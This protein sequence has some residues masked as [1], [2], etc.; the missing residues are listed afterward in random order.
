M[1]NEIITKTAA[2]DKI[3]FGG[4]FGMFTKN[5]ENIYLLELRMECKS[6]TIVEFYM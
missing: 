2:H 5:L 3:L 4:G 6:D 1:I